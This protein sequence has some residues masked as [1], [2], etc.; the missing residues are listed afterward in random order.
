METIHRDKIIT[1]GHHPNINT[2]QG[3]WNNCETADQYL[4]GMTHFKE[5]YYK[6]KPKNTFWDNRDFNF[7]LNEGLQTWT[8]SFFYNQVTK[9]GFNGKVG[10]LIGNEILSSISIDNL[11]NNGNYELKLRFFKD[12]QIAL[13]W[14]S[15]PFSK[16]NIH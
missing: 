5:I 2:L 7:Q 11:F 12:Q 1:I 10:V 4:S 15:K 13:D 14:F 8:N 6:T 3:S 16:S 9:D